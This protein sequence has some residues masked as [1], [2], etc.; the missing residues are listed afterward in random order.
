MESVCA[1]MAGSELLFVIGGG[2]ISVVTVVISWGRA[3]MSASSGVGQR[4]ESI[5]AG[6]GSSV[7][8]KAVSAQDDRER[9]S[10][11]TANVLS[12]SL[13]CIG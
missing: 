1:K 6:A 2:L 8:E 7:K 10:A 3:V 13:C 5:A 11:H 12:I 9:A 4:V